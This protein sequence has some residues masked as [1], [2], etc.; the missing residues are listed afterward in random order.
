[1]M[2]DPPCPAWG[3]AYPLGWG[4]RPERRSCRPLLPGE[5]S[6]PTTWCS[7]PCRTCTG[8]GLERRAPPAARWTST[9]SCTP[10]PTRP[11]LS[12]CGW[13]APTSAGGYCRSLLAGRAGWASKVRPTPGA[14]P[15]SHIGG[16][17]ATLPERWAWSLI[18]LPRGLGSHT[19]GDRPASTPRGESAIP[20]CR[21]MQAHRSRDA[22]PRGCSRRARRGRRGPRAKGRRLP[23]AGP[24]RRGLSGARPHTAGGL[25]R[26]RLL[27]GEGLDEGTSPRAHP[28]AA[29]GRASLAWLSCTTRGAPVCVRA[30][31]ALRGAA[32]DPSGGMPE[33]A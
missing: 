28:H 17:I 13:I 30:G 22:S 14:G 33:K 32:R 5:G 31:L 10:C 18:G 26:E 15:A 2:G 9:G 29:G 21:I 25:A 19:H 11:A 24:S 8:G 12:W 4:A 7:R 3:C 6:L 16:P 1:M 27:L 20:G 23:Q